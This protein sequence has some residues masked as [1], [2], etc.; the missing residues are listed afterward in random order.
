MQAGGGSTAW[1][2]GRYKAMILAWASAWLGR[3]LWWSVE[4]DRLVEEDQKQLSKETQR[5]ETYGKE[6]T[7]KEM[8]S[9]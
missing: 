1:V 5:H 6:E 7:M 4:M 2:Q 3:L 9:S 8:V